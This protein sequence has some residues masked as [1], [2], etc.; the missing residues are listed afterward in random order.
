MG[1]EAIF[2]MFM[3]KSLPNIAE[4]RDF[5]EEFCG[6]KT[7]PFSEPSQDV[8][9][10]MDAL[11][12][13][14]AAYDKDAS[15]DHLTQIRAMLDAMEMDGMVLP[16]TDML[17]FYPTNAAK[18]HLS[19]LWRVGKVRES[20]KPETYNNP[21]D[22]LILS[23]EHAGRDGTN[24]AALDLMFNTRA[25]IMYI[26]ALKPSAS[27]KPSP[28][29]ATEWDSDFAHSKTPLHITILNTML[30]EFANPVTI[31]I[32]GKNPA[33]RNQLLVVPNN[34]RFGAKDGGQVFPLI[35]GLTLLD[36]YE[37]P[38]TA[39][40]IDGNFPG[41]YIDKNGVYKP[42]AGEGAVAGEVGFM[43]GG[44][45]DTNIPGRHT[46]GGD[47]CQLGPLFRSM[48]M[49]FSPKWRNRVC[50]ER[51]ALIEGLNEAMEIWIR[52]DPTKK[53]HNPW[54]FAKAGK[55]ADVEVNMND[56]KKQFG[57]GGPA[58]TTRPTI[59]AG[60]TIA[61]ST[62]P[63]A[64]P[65]ISSPPTGSE[66]G[67]WEYEYEL[68]LKSPTL[69]PTR[70]PTHTDRPT[71]FPT[72]FPTENAAITSAPTASTAKPTRFP[73]ENTAI[74]NTPTARATLEPTTPAIDAMLKVDGT[75]SFTYT[76]TGHNRVIITLR[77]DQ[78]RNEYRIIVDPTLSY[79]VRA[80]D[81]GEFGYTPHK[82]L[83]FIE[84]EDYKFTLTSHLSYP[85]STDKNGQTIISLSVETDTGE[86]RDI[87]TFTD[88]T[89]SAFTITYKDANSGVRELADS[90][91]NADQDVSILEDNWIPQSTSVSLETAGYAAATLLAFL[92]T[93]FLARKAHR[94]VFG[95][96][97]DQISAETV[98]RAREV[99]KALCTVAPCDLETGDDTEGVSGTESF[100][101]GCYWASNHVS[102]VSGVEASVGTHQTPNV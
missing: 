39:I 41:S 31:N 34:H 43:I 67:D 80:I 4:T 30:D 49:E 92:V 12:R 36:K 44:R 17:Y 50:P 73:T 42:V 75:Y 1:Y 100:V 63:T 8:K 76:A 23:D 9:I 24:D 96:N 94:K 35:Y 11:I 56:F 14:L 89:P 78:G 16:G 74:T 3:G 57:I 32:H 70:K 15:K 19:F 21:V 71:S 25:K 46:N 58:A 81:E 6:R 28:C 64:Y 62:A 47:G 59:T 40:T 72:S 83:K 29:Q 84:G 55:L 61:P 18:V 95:T 87:N 65:T 99:K 38:D 91:N 22:Q 102:K 7:S 20:L 101:G 97:E 45:H 54:E 5:I 2:A 53:L 93:C 88:E 98:E 52:L 77:N 10:S 26:N 27:G 66:N 48:H 60:E 13:A 90:V 82:M 86:V 37:I 69:K 79:I 33:D 51:A 85:D 68:K